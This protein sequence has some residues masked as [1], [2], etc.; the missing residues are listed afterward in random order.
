[1][2]ELNGTSTRRVRRKVVD[3]VLPDVSRCSGPDG[4]SKNCIFHSDVGTIRSG[5]QKDCP[6][7]DEQ[8]VSGCVETIRRH[9]ARQIRANSENRTDSKR[10]MV[11]AG[12]VYSD[13][14]SSSENMVE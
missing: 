3:S 2:E 14:S 6:T 5:V 13:E 4:M 8:G 11:Q 12:N 7:I 1:M 9:Y 10:T